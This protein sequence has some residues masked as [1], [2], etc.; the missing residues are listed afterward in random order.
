MDALGFS[1]S[2]VHAV[3]NTFITLSTAR[4]TFEFL[5]ISCEPAW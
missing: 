3:L 4:V 1:V 2:F 5:L